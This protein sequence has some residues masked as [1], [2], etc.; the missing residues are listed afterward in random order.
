ML[1][2]PITGPQNIP[3][4][5]NVSEKDRSQLTE[6]QAHLIKHGD[7]VKDIAFQVDDVRGVW[8][9]AIQ[10]G[11]T[12]IQKPT[13]LSD[14]KDGEVL[15]ATIKTYGD[16]AHTL[17]NRSNYRGVFLP[18]FRPV[19]DMNALNELL[20]KVDLI[21]IDHCVGNQPWNGLDGIV[22]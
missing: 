15:Y 6:I 9:H 13:I 16:T 22:K 11:A 17:I 3:S 4:D 18:G 12:S 14:E 8:E 1:T 20:P 5:K 7:G 19:N 2:A 10:N 21:E